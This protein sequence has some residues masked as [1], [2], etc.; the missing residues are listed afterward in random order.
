M[1][2]DKVSKYDSSQVI[3]TLGDYEESFGNSYLPT[4]K[5]SLLKN[6]IKKNFSKKGNITV[7]KYFL[8]QMEMQIIN[9]SRKEYF[10]K[11]ELYTQLTKHFALEVVNIESVAEDLFPALEKYHNEII[12]NLEIYFS[13]EIIVAIGKENENNIVKISF[14]NSEK[15]RND[16]IK[17][18]EELSKLLY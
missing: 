15:S 12:E 8:R 1:N 9:N 3:I 11:D 18:I 2:W 16:C 6:Y 13:N 17:I 10:I 5:C 14:H 7:K 4:G